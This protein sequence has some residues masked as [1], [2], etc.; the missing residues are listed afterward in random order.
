[1][2][3]QQ[4][5]LISGFRRKLKWSRI[6]IN[7]RLQRLA[8][9]PNRWHPQRPA[10]ATPNLTYST[11]SPRSQSSSLSLTSGAKAFPCTNR[12]RILPE[13]TPQQLLKKRRNLSLRK[14]QSLGLW[15]NYMMLR[16]VPHRRLGRMKRGKK[17]LSSKMKRS[18]MILKEKPPLMRITMSLCN[19]NIINNHR[20][21][22]SKMSSTHSL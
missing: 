17:Q 9:R 22:C 21:T 12:T 15:H 5:H 19:R 1:M 11:R 10:V 18:M 6:R 20:I 8:A 7:H 2:S 16:A 3:L 13:Q 14:P 4:V